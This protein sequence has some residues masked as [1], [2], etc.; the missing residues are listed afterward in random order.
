M[1]IYNEAKID[2]STI[3]NLKRKGFKNI[4]DNIDELN[5]NNSIIDI[6]KFQ[7]KEDHAYMDMLL[8]MS[9]KLNSY[10]GKII[11]IPVS[12]W[13][14]DGGA[15]LEKSKTPLGCICRYI[16]SSP[17]SFK[18]EFNEFVFIFYNDKNK[19]FALYPE[20]YKSS[21]YSLFI[22][23]ITQLSIIDNNYHKIVAANH[24]PKTPIKNIDNNKK[25]EN[26]SKNKKQELVD[27]IAKAA[28]DAN[29]EEEAWE[30]LDDNTIKQLIVELEDEDDGKPNF[31]AAR[32]A[33]ISKL[34]DEF[35]EKDINGKTIKDIIEDID[36]TKSDKESVH[37]KVASINEEWDNVKFTNFQNQYNINSDI[38]NILQSF[39]SKTYP[40]SITNVD[41][42]DASTN[43][44]YVDTYTV[45]M[46]DGYGK[47]FT[48]VFDIPKL[49]NNRFMKLR[50]NDKV[51]S[52]QLVL[53]PC[54]KT[55]VDTVQCVSNYKKIFIRRQGV[56]GKSYPVSDKFIKSIRKTNDSKLKIFYGDNKAICDKY[57]LPID[58]I[59]IA[60]QINRIETPSKIYYFDQDVYFSKFN[61]D[62]SLGIP[63]AISK[64]DGSVL[65][66]K[67]SDDD[68]VENMISF[69]IASEI[70]NESDNFKKLYIAAKPS[71]RTSYSRASILSN[72]I[73]LAVMIG[74]SIGMNGLLKLCNINPSSAF[75]DKR[76]KGID[77]DKVSIIRF[78]DKNLIYPS[79]YKTSMLLNGLAT[80][81]TELYKSTDVNKKAMWLDFLDNFGGRIL[82]DGL[83]NFEDLFMDPIT[84]EVC[85]YCKIPSDYF[86]MLKY[87][88]DLLADNKYNRHTDISGNRFRTNEILAG[89]FY[90]A[91]SESYEQYRSQVKRGRRVGM[92]M[93]RSAV[94]DKIFK[95]PEFT[96]L[97]LLNP[98]QEIESAN[99][100]SFK[101][102]SG[103]NTDRAYGLD[104][105]TY[106]N[107]M[108]NKLSL[109]TGFASNVGI[110]RQSTIDMDVE[111]KRGYIK[112]SNKD[113]LNVTKTF[114]MSEAITPFGVSRD[115]PFRSAMTFTQTSKHSMKTNK[116]MPLLITNGSDEAM[117][118]ISSDVFAYKAKEDGVVI[119]VSSEYMIVNYKIPVKTEDGKSYL[120]EYINLKEECKKNSNG[121]FFIT[122]K[123]DTDLKEGSK[124][125]K[126]EIIAYDKSSYSNKNGE[127]DD[128]AYNVGVLAK[129]AILNTDEG[130]EDSTAI[131]NWLSEAMATDIIMEK[132]KD[133]AKT[134]NVYS[135]AKV[136]QEIQE[137][138]PLLIFQNSFDENDANLLLKNIT[139]PEYVSDLGR[140]RLKSK[141]T[142]IIQDIKIYRT[143]ELSEM[144][145]SLRK[146]VEDYEKQIKAQKK[147]YKKYNIPGE[148]ILDPDYKM[149][150]TGIM[151]NNIDGVKIVFYIKYNDKLSIGDKVVAQSANKGVIKNIFPKDLTPFSEYRSNEQIHALFA[152][153]SF[154]AR[155]VTSVWSSG[156]INKCMVELDRHVKE[157]MGIDWDPIELME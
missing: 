61:A 106:D 76:A 136:G 129:I 107:S 46:E 24:Q 78:E 11:Y 51:L 74:Y 150:P 109:S 90:Q 45:N 145:D 26:N 80:C 18:K 119:E 39:S 137:G 28:E 67:V 87:A 101:G 5:G 139:N 41:I 62:K 1:D 42:Q 37:L 86:S 72:K 19:S 59:D 31:S 125:K 115:D 50:G 22:N 105:R 75:I 113:D 143:C 92:S 55:D 43:Q 135:I 33:R 63:Y 79:S 44:D 102:L 95:D 122:I 7:F 142:G 100:V 138:D 15:N 9:S 96:D 57:E 68:K 47:K 6:S 21:E 56:A 89:Y 13:I 64:I 128:L 35:L 146:I 103:M 12:K 151:K 88:N 155:M 85:D 14:R 34:N 121:G 123:L 152:A 70:C 116:G 99:R 32:A 36:A 153:R 4:I 8:K 97:S 111:S 126:G 84:K 58:Y 124:F 40:I 149:A 30:E 49:R 17:T 117:P 52:G 16:K 114:C 20:L 133:L 112:P 110:T 60:S 127:T 157:I 131:S 148:N 93:K 91:I 156:A 120:N 53:L 130:F 140:I 66:Y 25:D 81:P 83:D 54:L 134:T 27:A 10:S 118:Y 69:I 108:I 71:I 98:L 141:Y 144:S 82:S 3:D 2:N 65:Y 73:P 29:S 154:N 77:L 132:D 23:T 94:I 48:L 104:K 147:M 38:F